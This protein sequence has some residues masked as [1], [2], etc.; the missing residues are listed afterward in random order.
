M[1]AQYSLKIKLIEIADVLGQKLREIMGIIKGMVIKKT[2]FV[3][4]VRV[5]I[6][7]SN[8]YWPCVWG[9]PLESAQSAET[10]G[11]GP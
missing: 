5:R 2:F 9:A 1:A 4:A 6:Q 8:S 11:P 3:G 10:E 7:D